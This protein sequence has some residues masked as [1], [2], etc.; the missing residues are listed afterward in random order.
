[1]LGAETGPVER[2]QAVDEPR[3]TGIM[4][5][6]VSIRDLLEAGVHFG[7]QTRRWNPKMKPYIYGARNGIYIIDLQKTVPLF[8][9][10]YQAIIDVVARG[11]DCLFLGTK[12]QAQEVMRE[13][14]IRSKMYFV[15]ARWLGGM[16]TN[17]KTIKGS[18]DH[19][20]RIE[21][22]ATDG[23]FDA[24]P[25]KEVGSLEKERVKLEKNLGGIKNM[26]RLPGI[27]FTV[28]PNHE[29]IG[30]AEANRL[31]I[32]VVAVVDTNCDPDVIQYPIPGNDDAIRSIKLFSAKVADACIEGLAL[33]K[34]FAT[35]RARERVQAEV[36]EM[37]DQYEIS[38]DRADGRAAPVEVV[39]KGRGEAMPEP[40][41][42]ATAETFDE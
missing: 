21:K 24:L 11:G 8:Q 39:R 17:W 16:L 6:A 2:M 26:A 28:D 37:P 38:P 3:E 22:M 19:L 20:T 31:K 36:Q 5:T 9:R 7:H 35:V 32:P 42:E 33:R 10:A 25:K 41:P 29:H 34:E 13:E 23:T 4:E 40:P 15:T 27:I 18:I 30:V 14:A 1:V 12:K